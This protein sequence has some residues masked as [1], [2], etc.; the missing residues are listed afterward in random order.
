M[1]QAANTASNTDTGRGTEGTG[2]VSSGGIMCVVRLVW[3][4]HVRS[5]A[6]SLRV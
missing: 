5:E 6:R 3:R 4:N 1:D 2:I